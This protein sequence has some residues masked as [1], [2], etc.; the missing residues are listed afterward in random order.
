MP[1]ASYPIQAPSLRGGRRAAFVYTKLLARAF[2]IVTLAVLVAEW[3]GEQVYPR[4]GLF[5]ELLEA[6][7]LLILALPP[8]DFYFALPLR[9]A[10]KEK[11]AEMEALQGLY[12]NL[13]CHLREQNAQLDSLIKS[14]RVSRPARDASPSRTPGHGD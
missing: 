5:Q 13:D 11:E 2:A 10:L 6:A 14:A 3:L 9:Q 7:I 8:L 12:R 4:P 1:N